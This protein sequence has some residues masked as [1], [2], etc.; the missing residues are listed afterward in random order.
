MT[1]PKGHREGRIGKPQRTALRQPPTA[2]LP[3]PPHPPPPGPHPPAA[4][5]PPGSAPPSPSCPPHRE[6]CGQTGPARSA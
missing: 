4:P 5:A 1:H 3:R 2:A 6:R